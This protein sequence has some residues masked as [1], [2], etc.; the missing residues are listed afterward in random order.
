MSR[1]PV[2]RLP[3]D[4]TLLDIH[5]LGRVGPSRRFSPAQIQ[6][7]Q[8]TVRRVPEVMVKVTGGGKNIGALAAHSM[9]RRAL[10]GEH[11]ACSEDSRLRRLATPRVCRH[12]ST[13]YRRLA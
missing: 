7:I 6:Q 9:P 13:R 3:G 4:D 8:R 10:S 5:S 11:E 12:G 2:I 1:T